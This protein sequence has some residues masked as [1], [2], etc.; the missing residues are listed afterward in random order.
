MEAMRKLHLSS[1][2][3]ERKRA[4]I[5]EGVSAGSG[6]PLPFR[7]AESTPLQGSKTRPASAHYGST[8]DA[9]LRK[10]SAFKDI[11]R[12]HVENMQLFTADEDLPPTPASF[13]PANIASIQI[14]KTRNQALQ[15]KS[16]NIYQSPLTD[17]SYNLKDLKPDSIY[18]RR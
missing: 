11:Q 6:F 10:T 2:A 5:G 12:P 4:A 9:E 1:H 17:T 7:D 13:G 14:Q 8:S 18:H 15:P 16:Q 3:I